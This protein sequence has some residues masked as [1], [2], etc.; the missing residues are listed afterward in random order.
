MTGRGVAL[1]LTQ[2]LE[3]WRGADYTIMEFM[4]RPFA[5]EHTCASNG[6]RQYCM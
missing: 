4:A 5:A 3:R 6:M 1:R 2:N